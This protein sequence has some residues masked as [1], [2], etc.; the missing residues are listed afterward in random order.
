MKTRGSLERILANFRAAIRSSRPLVNI[1]RILDLM[2][3]DSIPNKYIVGEEDFLRQR[4]RKF[5]LGPTALRLNIITL[6]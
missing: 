3:Q 6:K 1:G 4:G 2:N 5:D